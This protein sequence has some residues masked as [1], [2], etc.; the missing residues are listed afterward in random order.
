MSK[1][2]QFLTNVQGTKKSRSIRLLFLDTLGHGTFQY[3]AR[4]ED[5]LIFVPNQNYCADKYAMKYDNH[6]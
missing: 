2:E 4:I 1:M 3:G 5:N 6:F